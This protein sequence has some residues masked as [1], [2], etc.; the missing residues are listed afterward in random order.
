MG[1]V[2]LATEQR[3]S[4]LA[5]HT[6]NV[7]DETLKNQM[8]RTDHYRGTLLLKVLSSAGHLVYCYTRR[9]LAEHPE[10]LKSWL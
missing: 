4:K 8:R 1:P 5:V 6:I 10:T 2:E 7:D 9:A 3:V